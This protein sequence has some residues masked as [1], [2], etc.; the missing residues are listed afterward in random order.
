M[1]PVSSKARSSFNGD[2]NLKWEQFWFCVRG[3]AL[4]ARGGVWHLPRRA[5][6]SGWVNRLV[7]L[8]LKFRGSLTLQG[9]G[10]T[11]DCSLPV[12]GHKHGSWSHFVTETFFHQLTRW[13]GEQSLSIPPGI[14]GL[15]TVPRK[16][17]LD[18]TPLPPLPSQA[19]HSFQAAST[20]PPSLPPRTSFTNSP[21]SQVWS[22]R[23]F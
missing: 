13:R 6:V 1:D 4:I 21:L 18:W 12:I 8:K 17:H 9:M 19:L 10:Y 23:E 11:C 15:I 22:W 14:C 2:K 7:P 20:Y 5:R 3:L 16:P